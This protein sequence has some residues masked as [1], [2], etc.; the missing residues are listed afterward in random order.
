MCVK[1]KMRT[2]LGG[3]RT[4]ATGRRRRC[5]HP[6]KLV[7]KLMHLSLRLFLFFAVVLAPSPALAAEWPLV[8]I[9]SAFH[10]FEHHWYVWLPADP[11]YEAVEVVSR[12]RG[13]RMPPL[14]WVFFTERAGAKKQ[15]HYVNDRQLAAINGWQWRDIAFGMTGTDGGARGVSVAL[16]DLQSRPI[17]IV[18]RCEASAPLVTTGAGLTNQIGHSR[19]SLL[20]VFF[21][22]KNVFASDWHVSI[23]GVEVA[24]AQGGP[25][26]RAPYPAAYSRNIFVGGFQFADRVISFDGNDPNEKGVLRFV[27][28]TGSDTFVSTLRDGTQVE[29][30]TTVDRALEFYRHRDGAH[31][32]EVRFNPPLPAPGRLGAG[33][34]ATYGISLDGF[35]DVFT[36]IVQATEVGR[37]TVL[38]WRTYVPDWARARG[39]RTTIVTGQGSAMSVQ[40]RPMK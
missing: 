19:D 12:T 28:T 15:S 17:S 31:M 1:A 8:P 2:S 26:P 14:V 40:L 21:R 18:V 25:N 34:E 6:G 16:E 13:R 10:H 37:T 9:V 11:T 7:P 23:A 3:H 5:Y 35:R 20:L 38:D 32:L 22:E 33:A 24:R 39:F 29:L 36:G 27:Q 4:C 30:H